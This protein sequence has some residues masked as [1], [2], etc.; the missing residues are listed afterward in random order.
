MTLKFI[1]MMKLWHSS[2]K[3]HLLFEALQLT[4]DDIPVDLNLEVQVQLQLNQLLILSSID[5]LII[6]FFPIYAL[7]KTLYFIIRSTNFLESYAV[8]YNFSTLLSG[9]K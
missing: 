2:F 3:M 5:N 4:V 8:R 9:E 1:Y 6:T 7:F